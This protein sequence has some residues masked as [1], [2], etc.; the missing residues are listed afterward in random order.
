M[1]PIMTNI[2]QS[3]E[4]PRVNLRAL[5]ASNSVLTWLV[6]APRDTPNAERRPGARDSHMT[7]RWRKTD[8]NPRSLSEGKSW[9]GRHVDP[10]CTWTVGRLQSELSRPGMADGGSH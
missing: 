9:K 3:S 5:P 2:L 1:F 6:L 8:S 4:S 10:P 7:H